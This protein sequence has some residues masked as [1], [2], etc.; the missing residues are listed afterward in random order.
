MIPTSIPEAY[1]R[2]TRKP[3]RLTKMAYINAMTAAYAKG[4]LASWMMKSNIRWAD[5][6]YPPSVR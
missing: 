6:L 5:S 3:N 2:F 1:E 4:E